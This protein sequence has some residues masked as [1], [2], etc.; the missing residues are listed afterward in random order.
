MGE[1]NRDTWKELS[2]SLFAG[3]CPALAAL[4]QVSNALLLG[5]ATLFVMTT[6]NTVFAMADEILP[7]RAKR[8]VKAIFIAVLVAIVDIVMESLFPRIR[9]SLGI[10]LPLVAVNSLILD[11]AGIGTGLRT[12]RPISLDRTMIAGAA[13]LGFLV[14]IA[15]LRD[16]LGSGTITLY[17]NGKG[18][19]TIAVPGLSDF[20][21][22]FFALPAGA[23]VIAGY[24][25]AAFNKIA[26]GRTGGPG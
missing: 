3:L 10:Y 26:A 19:G 15:L 22:R 17:E 21:M 13:Y 11:E 14:L 9:K 4:T 12:V 18:G 25:K 6:A 1:K 2:F 16:F 20:P 24:L 23:L 5:I 8:L 7:A